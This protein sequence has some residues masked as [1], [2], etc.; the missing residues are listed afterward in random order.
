[1]IANFWRQ[2]VEEGR[3][4][5]LPELYSNQL[6]KWGVAVEEIKN[7]NLGDAKKADFSSS[8]PQGFSFK[9]AVLDGADFRNAKLSST[10]FSNVSASSANFEGATFNR[11]NLTSTDF[12]HSYLADCDFSHARM[13]RADLFK[14]NCAASSFFAADLTGCDIQQ[15]NMSECDLRRAKGME[16][17]ATLI[18]GAQFSTQSDDDWSRLRTRY[19]GPNMIFNILFLLSYILPQAALV[20]FYYSLGSLQDSF[21]VLQLQTNTIVIL[22]VL[23]LVDLSWNSMFAFSS[24]ISLIVYNCFRAAL[25]WFTASFREAEER[26]G[27]TPRLRDDGEGFLDDIEGSNLLH[28]MRELYGWLIPLDRYLNRLFAFTIALAAVRGVVWL[29]QPVSLP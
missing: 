23:G 10:D 6:R 15:T 12:S 28:S 18:R 20:A 8:D 9:G 19:S 25:T 7:A 29:F 22:A 3:S 5:D 16:F 4:G 27:R 21:A 2:L 11:S 17:Y 26:S 1:V 13:D 14:A 24:S